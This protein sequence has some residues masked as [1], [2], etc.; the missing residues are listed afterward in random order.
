MPES[1]PL[2]PKHKSKRFF[3]S[4]TPPHGHRI[5]KMENPL[6]KIS[7]CAEDRQ[8]FPANSYRIKPSLARNSP[9]RWPRAGTGVSLYKTSR[10]T[11][12][13]QKQATPCT[14]HH[15]R[16]TRYKNSRSLVRNSTTRPPRTENGSLL[17]QTN[18]CSP[19]AQKTAL[20]CTKLGVEKGSLLHKTP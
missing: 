4:F 16:G 8:A 2:V 18:H 14:N 10:R 1:L 17:H 6:R 9:G 3:R 7:H 13:V 11:R 19:C 20:P 5:P 15:Q 12:L